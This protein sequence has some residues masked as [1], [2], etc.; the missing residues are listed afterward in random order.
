M[1][2][3]MQNRE[4]L[5][6]DDE[7]DIRFLLGNILKQK[8]IQTVFASSLSE[9]DNILRNKEKFDCIFL[10]NFL[11]DGLGVNHIKQIKRKYPQA[12]I[13]MITAHDNQTDREK[14]SIEGADYFIGK[15]F[16]SESILKTIDRLAV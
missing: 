3:S 8:N 13:V 4:I 9:A 15:P 12:K 2:N 5:I 1:N 10:D 16:S 7:T 6:V 14:A 11:P